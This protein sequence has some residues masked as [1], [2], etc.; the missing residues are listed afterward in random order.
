[1]G[2]V[3]G[4]RKL[5]LHGE[6]RFRGVAGGHL[7]LDLLHA[8]EEGRDRPVLL[9]GLAREE[10][11][12]RDVVA[13]P[14]V[15]VLIPGNEGGG[16]GEP[17]DEVERDADARQPR[18]GEQGDEGRGRDE[19]AHGLDGAVTHDEA[20]VRTD[21][22]RRGQRQDVRGQYRLTLEEADEI[23][24]Q[25]HAE[26]RGEKGD[27]G[28][29]AALA[30]EPEREQRGADEL[31]VEANVGP[32]HLEQQAVVGPFEQKEGE[33]DARDGDE[34]AQRGERGAQA[35][36]QR[37]AGEG[38]RRST[39]EQHQGERR[40]PRL[41]AA[42]HAGGVVCGKGDEGCEPRGGPRGRLAGD[43]LAPAHDACRGARQDENAEDEGRAMQRCGHGHSRTTHQ[44]GPDADGMRAAKRNLWSGGRD[45]NP[46]QSAWKADALPIELP[47]HGRGDWI[48]TSDPLL[49]K[50]MRYQ[51]AP[52]P[53][54][55]YLP[56]SAKG[57]LCIIRLHRPDAIAFRAKCMYV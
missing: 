35:V 57:N 12:D 3:P 52:R 5:G 39:G 41:V 42:H 6:R 34:G 47:P 45:S 37:R 24:R 26:R 40:G 44:N 11:V 46:Q 18:G 21:L 13:L 9:V 17:H 23:V 16:E 2:L 27:Q 7:G 25:T 51:T 20:V 14:D 22:G 30:H 53:A 32:L 31:Q 43:G 49:P 50:Q 19:G 4:G 1:M 56:P 8:L 10:D 33:R 55:R 36:A 38:E 28:A 15:G 48:R 29:R 54:P